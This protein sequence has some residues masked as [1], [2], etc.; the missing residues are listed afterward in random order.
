MNDD[1][2]SKP[3]K[4]TSRED[5]IFYTNNDTGNSIMQLTMARGTFL[6]LGDEDVRHK[7]RLF[8]ASYILPRVCFQLPQV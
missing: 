7:V 3:Y 5:R 4:R 6:M 2:L 8:L 1:V